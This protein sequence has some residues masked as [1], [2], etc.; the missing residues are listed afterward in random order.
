MS[1]ETVTA[2]EPTVEPAPPDLDAVIPDLLTKPV[3]DLPAL[4]EQYQLTDEQ[5]TFV[6]AGAWARKL[7]GKPKYKAAVA[8]LIAARQLYVV[9]YH[10]LQ[11]ALAAETPPP[12]EMTQD[13]LVQSAMHE[14]AKPFDLNNTIGGFM[15]SVLPWLGDVADAKN[16]A[17]AAAVLKE[18]QELDDLRRSTPLD[19]GF[20]YDPEL[21]EPSLPRDR[22][23]V[24]VGWRPAVEFVIDQIVNAVLVS[25]REAM[26]S[27]VVRFQREQPRRGEENVYLIRLGVERWRGFCNTAN[28]VIKVTSEYVAPQMSHPADL[29][30]CDDLGAAL[31]TG[32]KGRPI[33]AVAGDAHKRLRDVAKREGAGVVAGVPLDFKGFAE[34]SGPEWEQL[35]T[36]TTVRPVRVLESADNL[37]PG[38]YRVFVGRSAHYWEVDKAVLDGAAEPASKLYTGEL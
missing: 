18:Q 26:L 24:L 19:I 3:E 21:E 13:M 11:D 15:G 28:G 4:F 7:M 35:R 32:F 23:L 17:E 14:A 37:D 38:K 22:S 9:A 34:I 6:A 12:H 30:V 10:E 1:E 31:T 27:T 20:R 16:K 5:R 33:G 2:V 8:A 25:R 29:I 36:F